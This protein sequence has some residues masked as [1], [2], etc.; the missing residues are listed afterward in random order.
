[1]TPERHVWDE[2][3]NN[4]TG[5]GKPTSD[6]DKQVKNGSIQDE[7]QISNC[8]ESYGCSSYKSKR[9]GKFAPT[10]RF[11]EKFFCVLFTTCVSLAVKTMYFRQKYSLRPHISEK[12][13]SLAMPDSLSQ[14]ID[15]VVGDRKA[16]EILV[17]ILKG[18]RPQ[19]L[20]H[21]TC[22]DDCLKA[23]KL[24]QNIMRR[25]AV[26]E[27]DLY[28]QAKKLTD[29]NIDQRSDSDK[30]RLFMLHFCSN[31]INSYPVLETSAQ[32]LGAIKCGLKAHILSNPE[33]AYV[34]S[35]VNK[36]S[37]GFQSKVFKKGGEMDCLKSKKKRKNFTFLH[38]TKQ[39]AYIGSAEGSS[40]IS[41]EFHFLLLRLFNGEEL[42]EGL[43]V[44]N[45]PLN[46]VK[47]Q[48]KNISDINTNSIDKLSRSQKQQ[49]DS[50]HKPF[51]KLEKR[52]AP[53]SIDDTHIQKLLDGLKFTKS[54]AKP[55]LLGAL[56]CIDS[57]NDVRL[58]HSTT[59]KGL[60]EIQ[61][62]PAGTR[63]DQPVTRVANYAAS[64]GES[65]SQTDVGAYRAAFDIDSECYTSYTVSSDSWGS[66]H[67]DQVS[68]Q[69]PTDI[70]NAHTIDSNN[71]NGGE[72]D[73][74]SAMI[75]QRT[76]WPAVFTDDTEA[77]GLI[78]SPGP[79]EL[80]ASS[81]EDTTRVKFI[82]AVQVS[83][84]GTSS[85]IIDWDDDHYSSFTTQ[86]QSDEDHPATARWYEIKAAIQGQDVRT[87]DASSTVANDHSVRR[88]SAISTAG[89]VPATASYRH[90]IARPLPAPV[91]LPP[92]VT[93]D[94][95]SV[96]PDNEPDDDS[97]PSL[98]RAQLPPIVVHRAGDVPP[99]ATK[100]PR[101]D[102]SKANNP[103]MVKVTDR[104]ATYRRGWPEDSEQ[105]PLMLALAGFY[106]T[107]SDRELRCF[108]CGVILTALNPGAC[109]WEEHA[110]HSPDC[111]Y[112]QEMTRDQPSDTHTKE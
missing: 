88:R 8:K 31:H 67:S 58:S 5:Q 86:P 28:Y 81:D 107:G 76:S 56:S 36:F 83:S 75:D 3:M 59:R 106:Y 63:N 60:A 20:G 13:G 105:D 78:Y 32:F 95:E 54:R 97:H 33:E 48:S 71:Y 7:V 22:V 29:E 52:K 101:L 30:S 15:L 79:S 17:A 64:E 102:L 12:I 37:L 26:T 85:I 38:G 87:N 90:P 80:E 40:Q 108:W 9:E 93:R 41:M 73:G 45:Q 27:T 66:V 6:W 69:P 62:V 11:D 10:L 14:L 51:G 112:L 50:Q 47:S 84:P 77:R 91:Q 43:L 94:S 25:M 4:L 19:T 68:D 82:T 72:G 16:V 109:P 35:D 34:D 1:M 111:R 89:N 92:L 98:T 99:W 110:R 2:K 53:S 55:Y 42:Q 18:I 39:D 74:D 49:L 24:L 70:E 104:L 44:V 61:Q 46:G 100:V 103:K 23:L 21:L 65:G 57:N 96:H